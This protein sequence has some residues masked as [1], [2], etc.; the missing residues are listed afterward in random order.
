[1]QFVFREEVFLVAYFDDYILA[2]DSADKQ[3]I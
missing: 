2:G 1:M 3:L